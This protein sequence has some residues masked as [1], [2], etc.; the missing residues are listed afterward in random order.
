MSEALGTLLAVVAVVCVRVLFALVIRTL[1]F[2]LRDLGAEWEA[3]MTENETRAER[4][5]KA[6]RSTGLGSLLAWVGRP[7]SSACD[8]FWKQIE[9]FVEKH[10]A[11]SFIWFWLVVVLLL[12]RAARVFPLEVYAGL[13]SQPFDE[14]WASDS[15]HHYPF[16]ILLAFVLYAGL[17]E[18]LFLIVRLGWKARWVILV[19]VGLWFLWSHTLT[20]LVILLVVGVFSGAQWAYQAIQLHL[21][22]QAEILTNQKAMLEKME[23]RNKAKE[24]QR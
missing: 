9:K 8:W 10:P 15:W 4:W 13:T 14:V 21:R 16:S 24:E 1:H 18:I 22:Q 23:R 19:L 11:R 2:G 17:F 3:G 7:V 20:A 6:L 12:W 5:G